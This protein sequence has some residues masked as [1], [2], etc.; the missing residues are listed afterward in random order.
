MWCAKAERAIFT[1]DAGAQ[2]SATRSIATLPCSRMSARCP[3][4]CAQAS[5]HRN[6]AHPAV[7]ERAARRRR[8]LWSSCATI[9]LSLGESMHRAI[10]RLLLGVAVL[11]GTPPEDVDR[12]RILLERTPLSVATP[13]GF[14]PLRSCDRMSASIRTAKAAERSAPAAR[15]VTACHFRVVR[16]GRSWNVSFGFA[17][18]EQHKERSPSVWVMTT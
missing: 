17:L 5:V 16:L 6:G 4:K 12:P 1:T 8:F 15:Q 18:R 10:V 7:P 11:A 14:C 2:G 9:E 3:T 13:S